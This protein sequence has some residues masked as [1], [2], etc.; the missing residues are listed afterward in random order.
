MAKGRKRKPR[1]KKPSR[2]LQL[3]LTTKADGLLLTLISSVEILELEP[4]ASF[5]SNPNRNALGRYDGLWDTGATGTVISQRVVD[6]CSLKPTGKTEAKTAGGN[7]H[8]PTFLISLRLPQGVVI[9]NVR[10]SQLPIAVDMLIGMDII[11]QGD[12]AI[13]HRNKETIFTFGIPSVRR[14][15]FVREKK[16]IIPEQSNW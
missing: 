16:H 7:I 1:K 9:N 6:E 8:A 13:T 5:G 12:F 11:S 10:V 2:P 4:L 14:L 15:D 3:C